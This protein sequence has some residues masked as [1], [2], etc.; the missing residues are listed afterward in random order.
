M[1]SIHRD[2]PE[3]GGV[4]AVKALKLPAVDRPEEPPVQLIGALKALSSGKASE[5]QQGLAWDYIVRN[6]SGVKQQSF[7][8][9]DALS[10]AFMEGRRFVGS[11]MLS[12]VT[13]D[14]A[15]LK[16]DDT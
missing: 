2:V 16:K 11:Q 1:G 9:D 10:M 8:A 7:R 3:G 14:T 5:H 6:L 13:I 15:R 12:I 4:R